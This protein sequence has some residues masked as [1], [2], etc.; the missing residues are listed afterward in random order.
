LSSGALSFRPKA[1]L[2]AIIGREL[3]RDESVAVS[4]LVK[5]SYDADATNVKVTLENAF[6]PN[7][8]TIEIRDNGHG[9][10]T[11]VIQKAWLE[12]ATSFK[13]E[14]REGVERGKSPEGRV[15]LGE[16]GIGRFAIDK[17]GK[18]CKIVSHVKNEAHET[19][20][21]IDSESYDREDLY[22]DEIKN[23]WEIVRPPKEFP[24]SEQG[25]I[26]QISQLRTKYSL[27]SVEKI[28]RALSRLISPAAIHEKLA[29]AIQFNCKECPELTGRVENPIPLSRA[30]YS[31]KG[32]VDSSGI[33][34]YIIK[35]G[36]MESSDLTKLDHRTKEL[37]R[38]REPEC[39]P[40]SVTIYAWER[41]P[42]DLKQAGIDEVGLQYLKE[43]FGIRLYR[44]G[45]RVLPYGETD[46]DWLDLDSR[47]VQNPTLRIGR[48]RILG[49]V[50][51]SREQNLGLRDKTSREG[52]IEEGN[53][54]EDLRTLCVNALSL[55][56]KYRYPLRPHQRQRGSNVFLKLYQLKQALKDNK[57]AAKLITEVEYEYEDEIKQW[58]D[59]VERLGDLAGIGVTLERVTHEFEATI[60]IAVRKQQSVLESLS[61]PNLDLASTTR[62]VKSTL[63]A[64]IVAKSQLELLSPLYFPKR[65]K[66]ENVSTKEVADSVLF[67]LSDRWKRIGVECNVIAKE[68]LVLRANRGKMIQ[69]FENLIDNALYWLEASET[70]GPKVQIRIDHPSGTITVSDNGLGVGPK[71]IPNLFQ[72]FFTTK[73]N[74]RGLGLYICKD[75]LS[76]LNAEIKYLDSNRA[77][78]GANFRISFKRDRIVE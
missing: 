22:L 9:M 72:P 62:L 5:N 13:R 27:E 41:S 10:T 56:E 17:L 69:I 50:Q 58:E 54:F 1:K 61:A 32:S 34:S 40:F 4:E 6:D 12:P 63:D 64:L 59:Q 43:N 39:G 53:A 24:K 23:R 29:F 60:A 65:G 7:I 15:L 76:E 31:I 42:A 14:Q 3:I 11:E 71:D 8:A 49:W 19:T 77:L 18:K 48:N 57:P 68:D 38:K 33:F 73:P 52:I 55:L 75:I 74:G 26:I 70:K 2:L 30:P 78:P 25:T 46:D 37:F 47:R 35:D 51:I 45:F 16:K 36:P 44:D 20:L 67:M 66:L 21:L 28:H